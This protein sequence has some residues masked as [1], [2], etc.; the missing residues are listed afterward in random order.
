MQELYRSGGMWMCEAVDAEERARIMALFGTVALPTPF[1]ARMSAED[2]LADFAR[3]GV[4]AR[5]RF[6]KS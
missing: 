6:H 5:L 3:R 1:M 2:V 4:P